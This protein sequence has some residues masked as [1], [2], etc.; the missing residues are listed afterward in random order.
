MDRFASVPLP[1]EQ[2]KKKEKK[3]DFTD[4][5]EKMTF[6]FAGKTFWVVLT[7]WILKS[8]FQRMG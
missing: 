6:S 4:G 5:E 1:N 8:V 3:N 7:I 2:E